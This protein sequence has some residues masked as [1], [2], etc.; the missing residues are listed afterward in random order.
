MVTIAENWVSDVALTV[1]GATA[2]MVLMATKA[3][4]AEEMAACPFSLVVA[5]A[6]GAALTPETAFVATA[7]A[8]EVALAVVS[9]TLR[10][11]TAAKALAAVAALAAAV[12]AAA[13]V[14]GFF[15]QGMSFML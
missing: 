5:V 7:V 2:A 13:V 3:D 14:S 11:C 8:F 4:F 6:G 1:V 10:G 9:V 12:L 15:L